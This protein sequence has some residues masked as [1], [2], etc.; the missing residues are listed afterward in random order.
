MRETD[1]VEIDRRMKT[2]EAER[3]VNRAN[4]VEPSR[5]QETAVAAVG[6]GTGDTN[7]RGGR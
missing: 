7:N 2:I 4:E 3:C 6:V 1:C 5:S